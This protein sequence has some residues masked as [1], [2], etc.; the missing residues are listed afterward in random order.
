MGMKERALLLGGKLEIKGESGK[1]T[2]VKITIP[3]KK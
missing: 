3:I 1:G 2:E